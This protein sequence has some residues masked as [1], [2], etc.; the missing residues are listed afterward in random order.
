MLDKACFNKCIVF[1]DFMTFLFI[2]SFQTFHT[3][4]LGDEEFEIPPITPPP[5][6]ESGLSLSEV[7][8]PFPAMPEP[9]IPQRGPLIPQF[10]PQSLDLPSITISRNMMDQDGVPVNNGQ[11]VV[12]SFT[13]NYHLYIKKCLY[14]PQLENREMLSS[15]VV[16][17]LAVAAPP[18]V[19]P[20]VRHAIYKYILLESTDIKSIQCLNEPFYSTIMSPSQFLYTSCCQHI[21]HSIWPCLQHRRYMITFSKCH[22]IM[23][24]T[25]RI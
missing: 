1:M 19:L 17:I 15:F 22:D 11:P 4:S 5:E 2:L 12:S 25:V 20:K 21:W 24:L 10:P 16:R 9:P 13:F 14:L 8:S 7:D 6:T 18:D 23:F 3:P